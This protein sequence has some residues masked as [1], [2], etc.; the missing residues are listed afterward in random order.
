[1][2]RLDSLA[3]TPKTRKMISKLLSDTKAA[4]LEIAREDKNRIKNKQKMTN[5]SAKNSAIG[6]MN[7]VE[8][9]S[10][11]SGGN[12]SG[13]TGAP[14][15]T[16]DYTVSPV[17]PEVESLSLLMFDTSHYSSLF[18]SILR[19]RVE[20]LLL[21]MN[22]SNPAAKHSAFKSISPA[23]CF[24]EQYAFNEILCISLTSLHLSLAQI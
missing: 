12:E 7:A 10:H 17:S 13:T 20:E 1:M 22:S 5:C 2:A 8:L 9:S 19:S 14:L 16:H 6:S 21:H 11:T 24:A 23:S 3:Q 18:S 4:V 15:I